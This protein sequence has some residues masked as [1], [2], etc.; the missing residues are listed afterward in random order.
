MNT[1][2]F[3]VPGTPKHQPRP[4]AFARMIGGRPVARVYDA[5]TAEGWKSEIAIAARP[6]IPAVAW[7]GPL[8]LDVTFYI[9]RPKSHFGKRGLKGKAPAW[10]TS[11]PDFDNLVKAVCDCLTTLGFWRD[12]TQIVRATV[13]K[14]WADNGQS[15]AQIRIETVDDETEV[16]RWQ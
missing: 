1:I 11:K 12:D 6:H 2:S 4:R 5:G 8:N 3:Y 16:H 10:H 13:A 14:R 9:P 15:G 7:M